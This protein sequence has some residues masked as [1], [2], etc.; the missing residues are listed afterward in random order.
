M[1]ASATNAPKH[2][3]YD[4]S[5]R[6]DRLIKQLNHKAV[7]QVISYTKVEN[8]TQKIDSRNMR[9]M[10]QY[11]ERTPTNRKAVSCKFRTKN[12]GLKVKNS[13]QRMVNKS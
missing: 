10:L 12:K 3:K 9:C 1:P 2:Y 6:Y 13:N 11:R 8:R 5:D 7:V 4:K